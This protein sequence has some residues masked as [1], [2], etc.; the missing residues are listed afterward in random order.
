MDFKQLNLPGTLIASL[1]EDKLVSSSPIGKTAG[2]SP[3][4]QQE[5][6]IEKPVE[7]PVKVVAATDNY[8]WKFL[9]NNN[10]KVLI[11]VNQPAAVFLKDEELSFLTRML[12]ACKLTLADSAIVNI[13]QEQDTNYSR[14]INFFGC[15]SALLFNVSP[16]TLEMPVDFPMYQ[17]QKVGSC[18]FIQSPSL[19]SLEPNEKER[20]KLWASLRKLFNV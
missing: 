8:Q 4:V 7:K 11:L 1:Y 17:L 6:T 2:F 14:L 16:A 13:H 5:N 15:T 12:G 20:G 19:D 9:G 10:K 18:T 3:T